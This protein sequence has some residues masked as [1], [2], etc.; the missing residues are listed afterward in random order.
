MP[1]TFV[2]RWFVE[3]GACDVFWHDERARFEVRAGERLLFE[4]SALVEVLRWGMGLP[5]EAAP[6]AHDHEAGVEPS[7]L[8]PAD[9]LEL[10]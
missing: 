8:E 1:R 2:E 6:Q 4:A 5:I 3:E 7:E 10:D 9:E